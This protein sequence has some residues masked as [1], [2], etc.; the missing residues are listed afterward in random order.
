MT[1]ALFW[2]AWTVYP[3]ISPL[4]PMAGGIFFGLGF[5]LLVMAMLNLV[6][7][8]YK[9]YSASAHAACG[10]M[11]SIG[12]VLLPLS[13]QPMYTSLGRHWPLSLLGFFALAMGA[14]PFIFIWY[15]SK[16]TEKVEGEETE[17]KKEESN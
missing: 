6:T 16:I 9:E 12:A 8:L 7:D 1:I 11:R 3:S 4:V 14:I 13:T 5:Q 10:T 2:L 17:G 15:G